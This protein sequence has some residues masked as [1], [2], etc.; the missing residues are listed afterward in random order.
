MLSTPVVYRDAAGPISCKQQ[1]EKTGRIDNRK[2][3]DGDALR[4]PRGR[5][6]GLP[7]CPCWNCMACCSF[8]AVDEGRRLRAR[9]AR[10]RMKKARGGLPVGACDT[11]FERA[12]LVPESRYIH[13]QNLAPQATK[14]ARIG[15]KRSRP[16]S[17]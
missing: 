15:A 2:Q 7:L 9:V 11:L 3:Q 10:P 4:E 1:G 17:P 12:P 14:I 13:K 8:V 5:P 16:P 6:A